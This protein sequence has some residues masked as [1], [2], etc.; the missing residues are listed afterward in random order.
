MCILKNIAFVAKLH[1]FGGLGHRK[2][3]FNRIDCQAKL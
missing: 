3:D 2:Q 1:N